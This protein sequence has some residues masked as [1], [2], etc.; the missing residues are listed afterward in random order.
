MQEDISRLWG[1]GRVMG[2]ELGLGARVGD[3]VS[4]QMGLGVEDWARVGSK[5]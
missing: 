1:R 5:S 4:V 3:G 2:L